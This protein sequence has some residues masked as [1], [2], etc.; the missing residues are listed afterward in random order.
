MRS[1]QWQVFC[2]G[3]PPAARS[4]ETTTELAADMFLNLVLGHSRRPVLYGIATDP[5]TESGIERPSS[6]TRS[7]YQYGYNKAKTGDFWAVAA[8]G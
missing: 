8:I 1:G 3:L 2:D 7:L 4:S 5:K 6:T